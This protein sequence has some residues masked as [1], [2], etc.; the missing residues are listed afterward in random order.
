MSMFHASSW[1]AAAQRAC[2]DV[3]GNRVENGTVSVHWPVDRQQKSWL[4]RQSAVV[5]TVRAFFLSLLGGLRRV[6]TLFVHYLDVVRCVF[7]G[8]VA[9]R[10]CEWPF[11]SFWAVHVC[12][13]LDFSSSLVHSFVPFVLERPVTLNRS[14]N[15]WAKLQ[16]D[17]Q[18]SQSMCGKEQSAFKQF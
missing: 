18:S 14:S 16:S 8:S 2:H 4:F 12:A 6:Q 17:W 1:A 10:L 9:H 5:C 3:K 13:F 15:F 11:S 7:V